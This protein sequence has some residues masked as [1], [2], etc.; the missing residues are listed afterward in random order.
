ML[1]LSPSS[2]PI[3]SI[4]APAREAT[5]PPAH[6]TRKTQFRSAPPRG[7]R[8][9]R[10]D[11]SLGLSQVSIRAPAR[12]ATIGADALIGNTMFRSAPPRGKRRLSLPPASPGPMF[13]SAPPRGKRQRADDR[14]ERCHRFDPRPRAG[15]DIAQIMGQ[16]EEDVSIRAPAREATR[17]GTP[18]TAPRPFRS[19]PPRGK[20]PGE[21]PAARATSGFDPRPRAG[22]DALVIRQI[23]IPCPFRSA[24]PRGKRRAAVTE[25]GHCA[26]FRS[27]P[28]RGKRLQPGRSPQERGSF[29]SAPPRGKRHQRSRGLCELA[30]FDPRPRAGSDKILAHL[31]DG[32]QF[33]SA[34]PR[35]KRRCDRR[36]CVA[37]IYVSI[38]APAREATRWPPMSRLHH[39]CFDP[40]PRAG[41]DTAWYSPDCTEAVSIRAPAREA[42]CDGLISPI[43]RDRFDPRPRAGSDISTLERISFSGSFDPRPRAGSDQP[44]CTPDGWAGHVSIRAPARE[45]TRSASSRGTHE[46]C[47]FRSA[48]PRGKRLPCLYQSIKLRNF[49]DQARSSLTAHMVPLGLVIQA[50]LTP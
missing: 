48:P 1:T 45:A 20:R 22:S 17:P 27:A 2:N 47:M 14:P 4:R 36:R 39:K 32:Q 44:P 18:P 46:R 40:R 35:G 5:T 3:V 30:C 25:R 24:P 12:E 11:R 43:E 49:V 29:R 21:T 10:R 23:V 37:G 41:S 50:V 16:F 7:K 13:R 33:R 9:R 42:T 34:P 8:R 15:S 38:R 26:L 31:L 19:A 28:P 6:W